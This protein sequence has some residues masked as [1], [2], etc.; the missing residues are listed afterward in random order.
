MSQPL[1]RPGKTFLSHPGTE[2]S[3]F[4]CQEGG[5]G[6]A[7]DLGERLRGAAVVENRTDIHPL[8]QTHEL[9]S[10]GNFY[11]SDS[12]YELEKAENKLILRTEHKPH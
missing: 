3:G 8:V 11:L 7:F 4:A 2:I 5:G 12:K 10:V 9:N 1:G 6:A